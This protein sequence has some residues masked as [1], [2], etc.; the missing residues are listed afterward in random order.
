MTYSKKKKKRE[1]QRV[2][3]GRFIIQIFSLLF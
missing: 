3:F 1:F 2:Y